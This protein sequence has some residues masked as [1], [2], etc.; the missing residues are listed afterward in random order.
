MDRGL[1]R[2]WEMDSGLY[3]AMDSVPDLAQGLDRDWG[4]GLVD[5]SELD[6][7]LYLAM[8]SVLDSVQDLGRCSEP[9]WGHCWAPGLV[10]TM[11]MDWG[12]CWAQDLDQTMAMD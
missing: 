8:D 6:S 11:A 2:C 3:S 12:R 1:G 10:Q 4:T 7:D 5:C 9:D